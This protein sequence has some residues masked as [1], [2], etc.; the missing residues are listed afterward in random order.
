MEFQMKKITIFTR[1][2]F[3][4]ILIAN[5]AVIM[6]M[7]PN[8]ENNATQIEEICT[9]CFDEGS[10]TNFRQLGCGHRFCVECLK[11]LLRLGL[12]EEWAQAM[13]ERLRCPKQ[14]CNY[15]MNE[16]DVQTISSDPARVARYF[17]ILTHLFINTNRN[18]RRCPMANCEVV[19]ELGPNAQ[20]ITCIRGCQAHYCSHCQKP[21][22]QGQP[23]GQADAPIQNN[24]SATSANLTADQEQEQQYQTWLRQ[25]TKQCPQC[26]V[27]IQKNDGCNHMT[28][29]SC[30]HE[31]CWQ[32]LAQWRNQGQVGYN[33]FKRTHE[34]FYTCNAGG[35][36]QQT[37]A[38]NGPQL[39][40]QAGRRICELLINHDA[41]EAQLL[42]NGLQRRPMP[43][44]AGIPLLGGF[45]MRDRNVW[46]QRAQPQP[47]PQ[48]NH[49]LE[50]PL[51]RRAREDREAICQLLLDIALRPHGEA[52]PPLIIEEQPDYL[53]AAFY[54]DP[55]IAIDPLFER[56]EILPQDN[57]DM[58]PP[59]VAQEGN[60]PLAE[61][62]F[63]IT[64]PGRYVLEEPLPR[65]S[66]APFMPNR[67]VE[68]Q[69]P[70]AAII[71]QGAHPAPGSL[72]TDGLRDSHVNDAWETFPRV[73]IDGE[74]Y[75]ARMN[76]FH[77]E[78]AARRNQNRD[79]HE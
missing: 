70:V 60:L 10:S 64:E 56:E 28:C 59:I 25:N 22:R 38:A 31:F 76:E 26:Q 68:V 42:Q 17:E 78:E 29:T 20:T 44:V 7:E 47:A 39:H 15:Q 23:C 40:A 16:Q 50:P 79:N 21:H 46:R 49:D 74:D 53:P 5:P 2:M 35:I 9:I 51:M 43:F 61:E 69:H 57:E 18:F 3:I 75:S 33:E 13:A 54:A 32:C 41:E 6:P 52:R 73:F 37:P 12:D 63:T 48:A 27:N 19:Y 36:Q 58:Q 45:F 1:L 65:M 66:F 67:N 34:G 14:N 72:N 62:N 77:D 55:R 30:R 71:N 4:A 24:N 11:D 8:L